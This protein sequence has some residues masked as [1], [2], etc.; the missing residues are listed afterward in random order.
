MRA[1]EVVNQ[2]FV[3]APLCRSESLSHAV[4]VGSRCASP[5]AALHVRK[6]RLLLLFVAS[7][8]RKVEVKLTGAPEGKAW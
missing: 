8:A 1:I 5:G 4:C 6:Y 2:G 7:G 3:H